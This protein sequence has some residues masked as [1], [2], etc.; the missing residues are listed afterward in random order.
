MAHDFRRGSPMLH[1]M[2]RRR[3]TRATPGAQS[4]ALA[5]LLLAAGCAT[6]GPVTVRRDRFNFNDAGAEST[7]E[8][9]LLNIVRLRYGEPIY[10]VDIGSMLSHY[11][12]SAGGRYSRYKSD[13]N[14]WNNPALRAVYGMRGEP[15]PGSDTW[16]ANL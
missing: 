8:Q 3:C 1:M 10:F 14:V 13:L 16:E 9:I 11:E 4:I 2:S 6:S 7:K 12:L 5:T 15:V